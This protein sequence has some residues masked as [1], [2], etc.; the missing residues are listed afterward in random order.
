[1][2]KK[3]LGQALRQASSVDDTSMKKIREPGQ[4]YSGG[5]KNNNLNSPFAV[6]G[7]ECATA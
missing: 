2:P 1:M 6:F 3:L 5:T 4:T 7:Y